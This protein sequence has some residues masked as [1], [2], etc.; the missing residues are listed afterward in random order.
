MAL[1]HTPIFP[2]LG[3]PKYAYVSSLK[4][5]YPEIA[6]KAES[7]LLA[8]KN[9]VG[10]TI[11]KHGNTGVAL[12]QLEDIMK[13]AKQAELNFLNS[14]G[15]SNG[16]DDWSVLITGINHILGTKASFERALNLLEQLA[17]PMNNN[18]EF[19]DVNRFLMGYIQE[20]VYN[21]FDTLS[22][23]ADLGEVA[24]LAIEK[25]LLRLQNITET[26]QNGTVKTR[27]LK[28]GEVLQAFT[29]L[30][31]LTHLEADN[32]FFLKLTNLFRLEEYVAQV[33]EQLKNNIQVETKDR[34]PIKPVGG[35]K[36]YHGTLSEILDSVIARTAQGEGGN[37]TVQWTMTAQQV[38][39]KNFKPDV[40]IADAHLIYDYDAAAQQAEKELSKGTVR[41]KGIRTMEILFEQLK[42][43][44]GSMVILSNKNYLINEM[45]AIGSNTRIP[46]FGAQ[47]ATNLNNL[48]ALLSAVGMGKVTNLI[49][50][51]ANAGE[52]M[53]LD[54]DENMLRVIAARI[55]NFL[56][57]DMSL[58]PP[59]G[60]NV[61]H[62]FN[63]SGIYVPLSFILQGVASGLRNVENK[64]QNA[65]YA[66]NFVNVTF[67]Q[68][69][70]IPPIWYTS[71][72]PDFREVRENRTFI[73]VHFLQGFAEEITKVMNI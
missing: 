4:I 47:T 27:K 46:G 33:Q 67:K 13:A 16:G 18:K 62:V 10:L 53:L 7:N 68:G 50:Y 2:L 49:D 8:T 32:P 34:L 24:R 25:G 40:I 60:L 37:D 69:P 57:D 48:E 28:E 70:V 56:F 17:D 5:S 12:K 45:F 55:A 64:M 54:L 63:L 15:F 73:E 43:A 22:L 42:D 41:Q 38:G 21:A 9:L 61:V 6:E 71:A 23:D 59:S 30:Y 58:T 36:R 20:E 14:H 72:W 66:D 51:F 26:M 3:P 35:S 19:K 29:D 52:G 1:E 44:K 11:T 39:G 31:N 65:S